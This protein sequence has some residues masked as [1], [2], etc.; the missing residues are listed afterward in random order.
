M[1]AN[2]PSRG[3]LTAKEKR[4]LVQ[5]IRTEC[6]AQTRAYEVQ[7]DAVTLFVLH[8]EFGFGKQR[9]QRFYDALFSKRKEMQERFQMPGEDDDYA[10]WHFLLEDGIDVEQMYREQDQRD[11][12]KFKVKIK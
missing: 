2:L 4:K 1:K 12:E 5:E 9:L 7:L 11:R 10:I 6:V 8:T 3:D